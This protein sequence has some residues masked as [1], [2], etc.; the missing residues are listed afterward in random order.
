MSTGIAWTD[1]TW[2]PFVGCTRVSAGCKNCY[3]EVRTNRM[4]KQYHQKKYEGLIDENGRWNGVTRF[5]EKALDEPLKWKKPKKIFVCSMSDLFHEN[6]SLEDIS[7]V[8]NMMSHCSHHTFQVLTKHTKRMVRFFK[9]WSPNC[10]PSP[11]VW[12]GTSVE[13]TPNTDRVGHLLQINASVLFLS[14]EPM[15][16]PVHLPAAFLEKLDWIICGGESGSGARHFD[17]NWAERLLEDCREHN[18]A[19][20]M[21]QLGKYPRLNAVKYQHEKVMHSNKWDDLEHWPESIQVQEFPEPRE[22]SKL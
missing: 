14:V 15:L 18:V 16:A 19:F 2:N 21:K 17:I 5:W 6:N 3:A 22:V 4:D 11:N 12:I 8:M 7:K 13:D 20:F 10:A 1:E 9:W